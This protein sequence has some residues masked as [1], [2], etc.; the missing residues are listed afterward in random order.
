MT[1]KEKAEELVEKF[2]SGYIV[3]GIS[4]QFQNDDEDAKQYALIAVDEILIEL[5]R[6]AFDYL[7]QVDYGIYNYWEEVKQEI[8]NL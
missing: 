8:N 3:D 1:T 6:L 7:L 5:Q 4:Y 2:Q